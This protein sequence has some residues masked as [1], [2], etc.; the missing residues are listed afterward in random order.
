MR[1]ISSNYTWAGQWDYLFT[2]CGEKCLLLSTD[3]K[4]G[5]YSYV[6]SCLP[7]RTLKP[8]VVASSSQYYKGPWLSWLRVT[9]WQ[10]LPPSN[11]TVSLQSCCSS[12]FPHFFSVVTV[13]RFQQ[14]PYPMELSASSSG[15]SLT[16]ASFSPFS[17]WIL[18]V[19]ECPS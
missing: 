12:L 4:E 2:I 1:I 13:V 7:R 5:L 9:R 19:S 17:Y 14:H 10:A 8:A 16:P 11:I 6:S 18:A 3:C 15:S